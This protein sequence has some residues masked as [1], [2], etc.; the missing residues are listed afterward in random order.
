MLQ[1]T[2]T[3]IHSFACRSFTKCM[4]QPTCILIKLIAW[5]CRKYLYELMFE[6]DLISI[7]RVDRFE[8]VPPWG[9]FNY[10]P[11]PWLL[12]WFILYL[13]RWDLLRLLPP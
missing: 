10:T 2:C 8:I 6:L 4:F 5:T 3:Y 7:V 1:P 13:L 9:A 12:T 11:A